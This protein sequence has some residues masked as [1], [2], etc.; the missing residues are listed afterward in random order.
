MA[1]DM[2]DWLLD[3]ERLEEVV[4]NRA[5]VCL[6]RPR[7]HVAVSDGVDDPRLLPVHG[8][9]SASPCATRS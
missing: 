4:S 7:L 1:A 8:D 6:P 5:P 3:H 2:R 9:A